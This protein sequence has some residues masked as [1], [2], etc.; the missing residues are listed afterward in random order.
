[1]V[2]RYHLVSMQINN[3]KGLQKVEL[4]F[5]KNGKPREIITLFGHQG[6]GKSSIILAFQWCAYGTSNVKKEILYRDRIYPDY[7]ENKPNDVI[8]VLIRFRPL[9]GNSDG[10]EDIY[11]KRTL[12]PNNTLDNLE[13]TIGS[14]IV[15]P[16]KSKE[17]FTQIFGSRPSQ[18]DGVMWVIR[19]EEMRRM[20]KTFANKKDSYYLDFMNLN[21]PMA[22]LVELN[23]AHKRKIDR[24][25]RKDT[26]VTTDD[27]TAIIS[28]VKTQGKVLKKMNEKIK[29]ISDD[30]K[31]KLTTDDE[32][33]LENKENFESVNEKLNQSNENLKKLLIKNDELPELLNTLLVSKLRTEKISI[34]KSFSSREIDWEEIATILESMSIIDPFV[35]AE[36]R[37]IKIDSLYNTYS[38]LNSEGKI[39]EWI[40]RLEKLKSANQENREH[41]V[42]IE[43]YKQLGITEESTKNVFRKKMHTLEAQEKLTSLKRDRIDTRDDFMSLRQEENR[44][45]SAL[46]SKSKSKSDVEKH[47]KIQAI[48][49]AITSSI[50]AANQ[51]Y[52]KE[53]FDLTL[54]RTKFFWKEIDLIKKY[55][56]YLESE[57][58]PELCLLNKSN[59]TIRRIE[60]DSQGDASGGESQLLLVCT[61]LAVSESSGAKMPIILD[62]C[63]TDVDKDTRKKLINVVSDQFGSMIFVTNDEDKAALL[64]SVDKLVLT[65]KD[66]NIESINTDSNDSWC[67]WE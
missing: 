11:C 14:D 22:G 66:T 15:D 5:T 17:Y 2:D 59:R 24:L 20:A 44:I 40:S 7:W 35:I 65:W 50:E 51:K 19:K 27:L 32:N 62:D 45:R 64:P 30:P 3:F 58:S 29:L 28:K 16:K 57:P 49:E 42:I 6:S 21:V 9:G 8:G 38:L 56:P 36:I 34:P 25:L 26:S 47:S 39:Q 60:I 46:T 41:R 61:C 52:L 1:M 54:E 37:N 67:R 43:D 13:V 23:K 48:I 18:N 55:E 53:M 4:D 63:F 31:N 10:S 12:D 33:L